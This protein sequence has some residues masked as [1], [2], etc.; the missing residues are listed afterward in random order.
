MQDLSLAHWSDGALDDGLTASFAQADTATATVLAF[1][2]EYD[3]RQLYRQAGHP[4]MYSY[5]VHVRHLSESGAYKRMWAARVARR[6]PAVLA[7]VAEGRLHL[8][9]IVT[10]AP[11]L[12]VENVEELTSAATH[13]TRAEIEH[14]LAQRFP[15][16]DMPERVRPLLSTPATP[17][18]AAPSDSPV[19]ASADGSA[20]GVAQVSAPPIDKVATPPVAPAPGA[21]DQLAPGRVGMTTPGQR[22]TPLAPRRYGIQFTIDESS[23]ERLGRVRALY[24]RQ[25]PSELLATVFARGLEALERELEKARF[26]A[27]DRPRPQRRGKSVRHIPAAVKRAVWARDGG[28]CTFVSDQGQR[29]PERSRLECDH[30]EPV[31]RGGTAT[32]SGIRLRC[33]AHNQLDAERTYGVEFMRHKRESAKHARAALSVAGPAPAQGSSRDLSAG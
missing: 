5:L 31:G 16:Q 7:A 32:V 23:H 20:A 30:I 25:R 6:F 26:S 10:L 13:K 24:G 22:V 18:S 2:G 33:R 15:R 19:T 12:S 8:S 29:C 28:R 11:R 27:T 9:G 21:S 3:A 14:L 1:I 4:S 17:E